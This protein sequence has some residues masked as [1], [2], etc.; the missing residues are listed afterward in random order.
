MDKNFKLNFIEEGR[1]TDSEMMETTGGRTTC[2]VLTICGQKGKNDCT[3]Y[4]SCGFLG[5]SNKTSCEKYV[6]A[7]GDEPISL[8]REVATA[9]VIESANVVS[10]LR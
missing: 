2:Q 9:N 3:T 5:L 6:W 4:Y 7:I 1:L 10:L 8:D